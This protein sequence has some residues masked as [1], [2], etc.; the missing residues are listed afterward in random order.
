[1]GDL[2][3]EVARRWAWHC[4]LRLG[5]WGAVAANG[6]GGFGQGWAVKETG[7]IQINPRV[8]SR[9]STSKV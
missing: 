4:P 9:F 6:N 2:A 8:L 7:N 1:M 3:L 5:N